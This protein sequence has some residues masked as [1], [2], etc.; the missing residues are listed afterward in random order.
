MSP[1]LA[2]VKTYPD[3]VFTDSLPPP[4]P[5]TTV[6]TQIAPTSVATSM[7]WER[8]GTHSGYLR[9]SRIVR[10]FQT[11]LRSVHKRKISWPADESYLA[12][13]EPGEYLHGVMQP[14]VALFNELRATDIT[15]TPVEC[16]NIDLG[17]SLHAVTFVAPNVPKWTRT[18]IIVALPDA[19]SDGHG[20]P[21]APA[22]FAVSS[23]MKYDPTVFSVIVTNFKDIYVF[24]PSNSP[25]EQSLFGRIQT[26][27]PGLA[28]R[29]LAAAC[30][31]SATRR[32]PFIARP[33][34]DIEVDEDFILPYGPPIDPN[35]P[36]T[37]DEEVFATHHRHSDFDFATLVRDR[38]RA[39]QF[40]RWH[41][42][43]RQHYSKVVAHPEDVIAAVSHDVIATPGDP[44]PLYPFDHSE[45]PDETVAHIEAMRRV[46][47]F[48]A[49]GVEDAFTRSKSFTLKVQTVIAEGSPRGICTVYRCQ[50]TS[51]DG[52]DMPNPITV[53]LKLFDDRFQ[54]VCDPADLEQDESID[55]ALPRYFDK[56][57]LADTYALNEAAAY[58]KLRPVQ[59]SLVPWFFGAHK[60]TL[61]NS[62]FLYGLLMECIEGYNLGSSYVRSLS[63]ESQ[64]A[65]IQ[66]CRHGARVLDAADVSQRD[67]HQDQVLVHKNPATQLEH[68]VL[69]DF[70]YTTQTWWLEQPNFI[71]NYFGMWRAL[72]CGEIA[73]GGP[74][75]E[76]VW[77]HFGEPDDWDAV[78]GV[79]SSKKLKMHRKIMARDMFPFISI[80]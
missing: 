59:G 13:L 36:L 25:P 6:S 7:E 28:I 9:F 39:L 72:R 4:R 27:Q 17:S 50:L 53:C 40:F 77:E 79:S 21:T 68:A 31:W 15:Q 38:A 1:V 10:G 71:N 62:L 49:A 60:F 52:H 26:S 11:A 35:K 75:P 57:I 61:P 58:E 32:F 19:L 42:H 30:T 69:V 43:I 44:R 37:P 76:L 63:D 23:A 78:T 41:A 74:K 65:I 20:S 22:L 5:W 47:P 54:P 24:L 70:A 33:P 46:S 34:P 29:A 2:V 51:I 64:I 12:S 73:D 55:E 56:V 16:V 45:L 3:R 80:V 67:W 18:P 48:A 14:V 8:Y 66:S